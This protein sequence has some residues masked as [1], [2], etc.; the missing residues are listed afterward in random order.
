MLIRKIVFFTDI[1]LDKL[2]TE[3]N[4]WI[5]KK[6]KYDCIDYDIKGMT[7]VE[8]EVSNQKGSWKA[9]QHTIVIWYSYLE[10]EQTGL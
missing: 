10:G 9:I 4:E 5:I 1:D 6:S 3:V 7:S 2:E 8:V